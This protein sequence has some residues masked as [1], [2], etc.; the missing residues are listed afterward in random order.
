MTRK[1]WLATA[2]ASKKLSAYMIVLNILCLI[3]C[4][5]QTIYDAIQGNWNSAD[6]WFLG[7]LFWVVC[8]GLNFISHKNKTN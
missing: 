7:C 4:A 8:I 2:M 3:S 6:K 1:T 5:I